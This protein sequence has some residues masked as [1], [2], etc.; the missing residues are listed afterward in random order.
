[1]AKFEITSKVSGQVAGVYEGESEDDA[2]DAY[3]RDAGYKDFRDA[4]SI[5]DPEDLD[6]E[7]EKCKSEL[8]VIEV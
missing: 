7:V 1:M 2:I 3:A 4:C 8:F 6:A 5:C